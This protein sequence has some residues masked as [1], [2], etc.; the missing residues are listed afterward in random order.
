MTTRTDY[1]ATTL[2]A[3]IRMMRRHET[4]LP[5]SRR[6]PEPN[7]ASTGRRLK[8]NVRIGERRTTIVLEA[9]VWDCIDAMLARENVMLDAFC[10]MD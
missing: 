10:D 5:P 3:S 1:T 8:R 6:A 2:D 7:P 9:Y 4:F